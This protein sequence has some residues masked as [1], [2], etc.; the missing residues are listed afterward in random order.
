MMCET[1]TEK[2]KN[3]EA[4]VARL[5]VWFAIVVLVGIVLGIYARVVIAGTP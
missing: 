2:M 5:H 1:H 4:V 3:I